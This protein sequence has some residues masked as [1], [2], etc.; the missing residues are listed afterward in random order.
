MMLLDFDAHSWMRT[1]N[2][3]STE[4]CPGKAVASVVP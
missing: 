2:G 1:L 4:V 3:S